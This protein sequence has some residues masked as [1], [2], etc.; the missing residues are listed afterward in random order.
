[1]YNFYFVAN[2]GVSIFNIKRICFS[3]LSKQVMIR[4]ILLA[5]KANSVL[6]CPNTTSLNSV[7]Q[8]SRSHVIE[9]VLNVIDIDCI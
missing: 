4:D 8:I 7:E 6:S 9:N 2:Y 1:M 5:F 3:L